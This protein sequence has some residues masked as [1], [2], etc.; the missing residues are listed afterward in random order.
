MTMNARTLT[1]TATHWSATPDGYGGY[2]F[3]TPET[4]KCRWEHRMEIIRLPN[5]EEKVVNAVV[6]LASDVVEGDYLYLGESTEADPTTLV[7]ASRV[8]RFARITALCSL[9]V[10]RTAYL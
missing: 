6:H 2:T 5:N 1:E 7:G 3:G 4:I 8:M 10:S 9:R